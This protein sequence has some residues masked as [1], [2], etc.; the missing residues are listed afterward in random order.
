M[1]N[2]FNDVLEPWWPWGRRRTRFV[3]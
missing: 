3:E 1:R 2:E